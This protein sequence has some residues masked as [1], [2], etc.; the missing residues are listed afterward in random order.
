MPIQPDTVLV[1]DDDL[2]SLDLIAKQVLEPS[3]YQVTTF[4]DGTAALQRAAQLAPTLMIISLSL[5]GFSGKDL[6]TALRAQNFESPI[7]VI[8][9]RGGETQA[10]AAFRL[11]A[12]DYLVRPLREAEIVNAVDRIIGE[13][14]LKRERAQLEAQLKQANAELEGRVKELVTLSS[15]GKAVISLNDIGALF[16]RLVDGA[17][18]LTGAEMAWLALADEPGG[19]LILYAA[20][21]VPGNPKLRGPWDDGLSSLVMQSGEALNI[22]GAGMA[23]FRIAQIA[24]SA[25]VMPIKARDQAVGVLTVAHKS[26]KVFD[27]RLVTLLNAVADYASI[28]VVNVRLFQALEARARSLQQANE[29]LRQAEKTRS[30]KTRQEVQQKVAGALREPIRQART[31][32]DVSM[33]EGYDKLTGRQRDNVKQ[34]ADKLA[35]IEQLIEG[36]TVTP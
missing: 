36:I 31:Y 14:R 32:M 33:A 1:V 25:L 17:M 12:R 34:I 27:N 30:L 28:A 11:G 6:L 16:A 7:I 3:G 5:Q 29:E 4:T 19:Q 15:V 26:A 2:E 9:P 22:T 10:L 20:K 8:A 13:G 23:Q 18:Q 35:L 21:N 24:R